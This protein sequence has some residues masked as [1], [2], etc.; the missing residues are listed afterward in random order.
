MKTI[1]IYKLYIIIVG[2]TGSL[3][4][5]GPAVQVGKA[6]QKV[7]GTSNLRQMSHAKWNEGCLRAQKEVTSYGFKRCSQWEV[8]GEIWKT[9][10]VTAVILCDVSAIL[11]GNCN[12]KGIFVEVVYLED[13]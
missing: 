3:H 13:S 12:G 7:E 2:S 6:P 8:A 11:D 9:S 10:L 1:S 4:I 5:L